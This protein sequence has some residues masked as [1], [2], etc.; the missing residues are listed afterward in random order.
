[1]I[2]LFSP[3]TKKS[4]DC[5]IIQKH[6]GETYSYIKNNSNLISINNRIK[7]ANDRDNEKTK[8]RLKKIQKQIQERIKKNITINIP[9]SSNNSTINNEQRNNR[10]MFNTASHFYLTK[11]QTNS[12]ISFNN[13]ISNTINNTS[14]YNF[15]LDNLST[16]QSETNINHNKIKILKLKKFSS[17]TQKNTNSNTRQN[18][19]TTR[20]FNFNKSCLSTHKNVN[21]KSNKKSIN[22]KTSKRNSIKNYEKY[23][24]A[25]NTILQIIDTQKDKNKN[26]HKNNEKKF[27]SNSHDKFR[28]N[29][30]LTSNQSQPLIK[31]NLKKTEK[32]KT[33]K[34]ILI[35][36][37][38]INSKKHIGKINGY[39]NSIVSPKIKHKLENNHSSKNNNSSTTLRIKLDKILEKKISLIK[40]INSNHNQKINKTKINP[41]SYQK[42]KDIK[43]KI[44]QQPKKQQTEKKIVILKIKDKINSLISN[45]NRNKNNEI[46]GE[47]P[48]K[49]NS[50][51]IFEIIS[52]TKVKS[53][54]EY[55]NDKLCNKY[56]YNG[57]NLE[58][59]PYDDSKEEYLIY[60]DN[61]GRFSFRP[62]NNDKNDMSFSQKQ[63]GKNTPDSENGMKV[64]TKPKIRIF[65]KFQ[66]K[67]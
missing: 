2:S 54:Y 15:Y 11:N 21:N 19:Q 12:T 62:L 38:N 52:N 34:K 61:K 23:T 1:M 35:Q 24:H 4:Q 10:K 63:N 32:M 20:R 50:D 9:H 3:R 67:K 42:S 16:K 28:T 58:Q 51:E 33:N 13:S 49:L 18:G 65:H 27:I 47:N 53:I 25:K 45:S 7:Q 44:K 37:K 36:T 39:A 46:N 55:E 41:S 59:I 6:T 30:T 17:F 60:S 66:L 31:I 64:N 5:I 29:S 8:I 22:E 57:R 14:S 48:N 40:K 26:D 56:E 43:P